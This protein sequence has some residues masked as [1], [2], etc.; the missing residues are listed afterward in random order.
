MTGGH[1]HGLRSLM[2]LRN[3]R[4]RSVRELSFGGIPILWRKRDLPEKRRRLGE[5]DTYIGLAVSILPSGK[6]H[7]A[8]HLFSCL[9]I[10]DR[11]GLR[12]HHRGG[13][14]HHASMRADQNGLGC[15]LKTL[16]SA[17]S[18]NQH[19]DSDLNTLRAPPLRR[20]IAV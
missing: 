10:D 5:L 7:F 16:A 12:A 18:T 11:Y 2:L 15:F 19:G 3:G 9:R 17:L 8:R 20:I 1:P 6:S 13:Q 14:V 4:L